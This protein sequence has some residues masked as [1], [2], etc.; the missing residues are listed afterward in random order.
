M[1]LLTELDAFHAFRMA[2]SLATI[3]IGFVTLKRREQWVDS[4]WRWLLD[5]DERLRKPL[6]ILYVIIGAVLIALGLNGLH[7][8]AGE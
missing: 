7:N 6:E 3:V 2:G 1:G 5:L 8:L 4:G